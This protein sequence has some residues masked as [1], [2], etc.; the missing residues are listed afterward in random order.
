MGNSS[1]K[2]KGNAPSRP[3]SARRGHSQAADDFLG[4]PSAQQGSGVERSGGHHVYNSRNGN[5][6]GSRPDLSFLTSLSRDRNEDSSTP[7]R[8]RETKIEREARRAERDRQARLKERERSLREEHVDGGF[9]VTLGTYTGPEDFSKS[10]VRHLQIE[11]RLAPFWRG[12]NDHSDSWTEAQLVAAARGLPIPAA[13]AV[14][15]ESPR[16]VSQPPTT[17]SNNLVP[18]LAVPIISRSQSAQSDVNLSAS[19]PTFTYTSVSPM[20]AASLLRT[21]AK[22]L[23]ALAAGN[24]SSALETLHTPN[25]LPNDPYVNGLPLEAYLYREPEECPICFM[26][27]PPYLNKTRCCDQPIC[28][29]CFVQIKRP[30]PH[31]PEHEQPGEERLPDEGAETL[32][33]EVAACPFCVT[34]EFGVSYE[35]PPFRRGLAYPFQTHPLNAMKSASSPKS[36]STTSL[37]SPGNRRRTTSLSANAPQVIT[38]DMVRPDWAKKLADARAN[39]LRRSIAATAL[40]N[41]A[42]VL[43]NTGEGQHRGG[44]GFGRRRRIFEAS[45]GGSGTGTPRED[46]SNDT[47]PRSGRRVRVDDIEELMMMEAIRLSLA[48]EEDRKRKEEKD[49]KK[50]EKKRAKDAKKEAKQAEKHARRHGSGSGSLYPVGTNDSTSTWGSTGMSRSMSNLGS[51]PIPEE[52]IHGKGKAPVQTTGASTQAS[53]LPAIVN[54]VEDPQGHLEAS[55]AHINPT[56]SQPINMANPRSHLRQLSSTSSVASSF[57]DSAPGSYLGADSN[58]AS[59]TGSRIDLSSTN[60][61]SAGTESMFNF[62]SLAAMVGDED[63]YRTDGEHIEHGA[64]STPPVE[65]PSKEEH[66][67]EVAQEETNAIGTETTNGTR[68]RVD[69][70][71]S[72]GSSPPPLF[73]AHAPSNNVGKSETDADPTGDQITPAPVD[74]MHNVVNTKE[75]SNVKVLDQSH[76]HE[77]TQ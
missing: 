15:A 8:P 34:P 55:R 39:A 13:D 10:T 44:L 61:P 54:A 23:T 65:S 7:E 4:Q 36:S 38:T 9:L 75:H 37:P 21:R 70:A 12:L 53:P 59:A 28:S 74:I 50:D 5:G 31:P 57:G 45:P 35:P 2:D 72:S 30:D 26:Y 76:T 68:G 24:K 3:S 32:V 41:A 18:G 62:R 51:Q 73:N 49:A 48:A 56:P 11:R 63:K 52:Q 46:G 16:V 58:N 60:N 69:S 64:T 40:H 77:A 1:S 33:S 43:G 29:E 42:Y 25:M 20:S 71:E 47:P 22:T 14:P 6:R 19:H 17:Q 67:A 27:Y 66:H